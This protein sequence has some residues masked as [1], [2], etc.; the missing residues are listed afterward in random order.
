MKLNIQNV[1]IKNFWFNETKKYP[2]F[3]NFEVHGCK[4]FSSGKSPFKE[5][6]VEQVDDDEAE[7]WSVYIHIVGGGLECIADCPTKEIALSLTNLLEACC[8][9]YVTLDK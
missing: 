1:E 6:Y 4:E 5:S 8:K 3:D 9:R 7:F 2:T